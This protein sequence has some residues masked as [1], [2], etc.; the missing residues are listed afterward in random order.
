MHIF[1]YI[2]I[3][4]LLLLPIIIIITQNRAH[5]TG[6]IHIYVR[7][8]PTERSIEHTSKQWVW[9]YLNGGWM[10]GTGKQYYNGRSVTERHGGNIKRRE[11][12]VCNWMQFQS[13]IRKASTQHLI[14]GR[15]RANACSSIIPNNTIETWWVQIC[16]NG[17]QR[18]SLGV[19]QILIYISHANIRPIC[20]Y[21]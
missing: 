2:Y 15:I 20:S 7:K 14:F 19:S 3:H 16:I 13:H 5:R 1:V 9:A 11:F 18:N 4:I 8:I 17:I 21:L 10:F 12:G 6:H